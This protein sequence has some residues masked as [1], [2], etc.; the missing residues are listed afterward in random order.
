[1]QKYER[2]ILFVPIK[3]ISENE[4][5]EFPATASLQKVKEKDGLHKHEFILIEECN[6][7]FGCKKYNEIIKPNSP[8]DTDQ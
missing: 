5:N 2:S 4:Y 1:V 3:L 7:I 8:V 6:T